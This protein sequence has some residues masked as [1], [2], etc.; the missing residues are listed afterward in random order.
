[1]CVFFQRGSIAADAHTSVIILPMMGCFRFNDVCSVLLFF[2]LL[3]KVCT[4]YVTDIILV[5]G[6]YW[7]QSKLILLARC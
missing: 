1:M 7:H 2:S 5:V 6:N 3:I 4:F